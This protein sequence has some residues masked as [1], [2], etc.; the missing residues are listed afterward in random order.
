MSKKKKSAAQLNREI[1][2]VVPGWARGLD[3]SESR[4]LAATLH[5]SQEELECKERIA[6]S[7]HIARLPSLRIDAR[8]GTERG[9]TSLRGVYVY[10]STPGIAYGNV[11]AVADALRAEGERVAQI[12]PRYVRIAA[13]TEPHDVAER[14]AAAL[15]SRGYRVEVGRVS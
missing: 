6:K 3:L 15:R 14:V 5:T 8:T 1:A 2:E 11:H 7:Q 12:E 9:S 13:D 4:R 10:V